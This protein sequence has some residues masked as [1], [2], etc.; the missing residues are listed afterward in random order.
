MTKE[1]K[2]KSLFEQLRQIDV[3]KHIEKKNKFSYLSWVWALDTMYQFDDKAKYEFTERETFPDGTVMVYCNVKIQGITKRG[4][5]PVMDYKNTAVSNPNARQISDA[6]Q[7]CL[8]KTI[9]LHGLG[10]S[11]YAGE[12]LPEDKADKKA[13][14]PP[15]KPLTGEEFLMIQN[16]LKNATAE[17]LETEKQKAKVV[18]SR[19]SK[20]QRASITKFVADADKRLDDIPDFKSGSNEFDAN[21]MEGK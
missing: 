4:F 5:L 3:T 1:T 9:A 6:M 11:L 14:T 15:V 12:D 17:T 13:D 21:N 2:E 20:E 18:W 7:R 19:A 10:L 8:V 16:G